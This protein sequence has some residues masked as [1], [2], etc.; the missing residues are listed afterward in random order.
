MTQS[1]ANLEL[2]L[3]FGLPPE[4]TDEQIDAAAKSF[5]PMTELFLLK[6]ADSKKREELRSLMGS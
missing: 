5:N 6:I 1:E 3:S 2:R 4:V